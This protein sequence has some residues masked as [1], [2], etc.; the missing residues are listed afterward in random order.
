MGRILAILV[1]LACI[2]VIF[3]IAAN[4]NRVE[5]LNWTVDFL[6]SLIQD[7]ILNPLFFLA[8]QYIVVRLMNSAISKK[9]SK[10]KYAIGKVLDENIRELSVLYSIISD[11][12]VGQYRNDCLS[13]TNLSN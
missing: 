11:N 8:F 3:I 10:F 9:S 13:E 5:R 4:Q 1:A 2:L 12:L 6:K 7:L